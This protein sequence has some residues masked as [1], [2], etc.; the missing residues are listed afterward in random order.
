MTEK[1]W[2]TGHNVSVT[3][4]TNWPKGE[5]WLHIFPAYETQTCTHIFPYLVKGS[6][7]WI[8]KIL[9]IITAFPCVP[10]YFHILLHERTV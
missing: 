6:V 7:G 4:N 3:I 8:L 9:A 2:S 1:G 10:N 5:G